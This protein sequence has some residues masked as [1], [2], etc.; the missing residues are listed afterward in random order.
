MA[1]AKYG[2]MAKYQEIKATNEEISRKILSVNKDCEELQA[3]LD[4]LPSV[5]SFLD[6]SAQ[7]LERLVRSAEQ[8]AANTNIVS[9]RDVYDLVNHL[10]NLLVSVSTLNVDLKAI[11]DRLKHL[12]AMLDQGTLSYAQPLLPYNQISQPTSSFDPDSDL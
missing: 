1:D 4:N 11:K 5:S 9:K 12:S 2:L 3:N 8:V 7:E 10:H 6:H